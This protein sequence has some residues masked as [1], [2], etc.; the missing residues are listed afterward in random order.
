MAPQDRR[1]A[2]MV[3]SEHQLTQHRQ[4]YEAA[5]LQPPNRSHPMSR[6]LPPRPPFGS[7]VRRVPSRYAGCLAAVA[8][9]LLRLLHNRVPSAE[10]CVFVTLSWMYPAISSPLDPPCVQYP[11]LF[12]HRVVCTP[13]QAVGSRRASMDAHP[14]GPYSSPRAHAMGLEARPA[15]LLLPGSWLGSPQFARSKEA[16][17]CHEMCVWACSSSGFVTS[18][19]E[20]CGLRRSAS[21]RRSTRLHVDVV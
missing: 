18:A 11:R 12:S 7:C 3:I 2:G 6:P 21:P 10:E 5:G 19:N 17:I 14:R 4:L 20:C 1:Q 9:R 8:V 16:C 13:E 15:H